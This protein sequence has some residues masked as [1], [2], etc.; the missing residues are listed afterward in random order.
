MNIDEVLKALELIKKTC[1]EQAG[2]DTCPFGNTDG[3]C[4]INE[5]NPSN[6]DIPEKQIIRLLV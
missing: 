2:C 6:W 5:E 4:K 1:E 3:G